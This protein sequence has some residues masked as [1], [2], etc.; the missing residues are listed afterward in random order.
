[1]FR[2]RADEDVHVDVIRGSVLRIR[3]LTKG[4]QRWEHSLDLAEVYADRFTDP[5]AHVIDGWFGSAGELRLIVHVRDPHARLL[6]AREL[7]FA[8]DAPRLERARPCADRYTLASRPLRTHDWS[9]TTLQLVQEL[10]QHVL[11][12]FG[13]AVARRLGWSIADLPD[14]GYRWFERSELGGLP[15]LEHASPCP[16]CSILP[17]WGTEHAPGMNPVSV[18]REHGQSCRIVE[19]HRCLTSWQIDE[20]IEQGT[21]KQLWK[22]AQLTTRRRP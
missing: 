21:M 8:A 12:I 11:A 19:C 18:D 13:V 5:A 9:G 10:D 2:L 15:V 16:T 20:V 1:M 7:T 17:A 22:W 4:I 6:P 14:T 3:R